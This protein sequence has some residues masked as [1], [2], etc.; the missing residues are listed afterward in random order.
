LRKALCSSAVRDEP[1]INPCRPA[2]EQETPAQT[3][4]RTA[5][6]DKDL[7]GDLLLRNFWDRNKDAIIDIVVV[8]TD[9]KSH[10]TRDPLKVL[11]GYEKRKKAKYLAACFDQRRDFTPFVV[12]VDGL[13]SKEAQKLL[14]RL[15]GLLA[16]KWEKPYATVC[17][18]VRA[19]M[20]FAILRATHRCIRGSRIPVA[21]ISTPL[22]L[23]EDQAGLG[24]YRF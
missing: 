5:A 14:Q 10:I 19:T 9:A 24:L 12:S 22:P 8:D 17:A 11:E 13:I 18:Y 4:V 3:G 2:S 16:K 6:P 20:S 1:L 21:Q 7:R 23:W 15:S